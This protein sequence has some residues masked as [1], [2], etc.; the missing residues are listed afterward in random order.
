MGHF[1][2]EG[3]IPCLIVTGLS[4]K[5]LGSGNYFCLLLVLSQLSRVA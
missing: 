4:G 1:I 3:P 2:S 5:D